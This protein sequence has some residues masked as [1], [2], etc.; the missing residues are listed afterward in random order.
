[1]AEARLLLDLASEAAL[2]LLWGLHSVV[3]DQPM[4]NLLLAVAVAWAAH[5]S[6]AAVLFVAS[7]AGSG[8]IGAHAAIA[9][10]LGV[11]P[12]SEANPATRSTRSQPDHERPSCGSSGLPWGFR[13][14][15]RVE[16]AQQAP[17]AGDQGDLLGPPSG[18]ERI[19]VGLQDG[20]ASDRH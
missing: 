12:G 16:D 1:M 11:D 20:V 8:V 7:L 14:N 6:V 9:M 19:V 17:D 13:P 2:L 4:P 5:S 10:D 3:A 15:D 18:D